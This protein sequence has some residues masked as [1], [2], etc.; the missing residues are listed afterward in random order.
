ML[1]VPIHRTNKDLGLQY[2]KSTLKSMKR[3]LI[4]QQGNSQVY[5]EAVHRRENLNGD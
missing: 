1:F 5:D 2:I 3:K 4:I